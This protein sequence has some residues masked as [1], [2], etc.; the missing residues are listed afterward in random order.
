IVTLK[1]RKLIDRTSRDAQRTWTRAIQRHSEDQSLVHPTATPRSGPDVDR[2]RRN[3]EHSSGRS[4][5]AS[6]L[7]IETAV[8]KITHSNGVHRHAVVNCEFCLRPVDFVSRNDA[9]KLVGLCA[10]VPF[11]NCGKPLK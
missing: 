6:C 11:A 5:H 2:I 10:F 7:A 1:K 8:S 4:H 3:V 9:A